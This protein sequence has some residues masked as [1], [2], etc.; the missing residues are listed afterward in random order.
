MIYIYI[1]VCV[2][3]YVYNVITAIL[4]IHNLTIMVGVGW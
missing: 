1:Y 3:M 2:F 4:T